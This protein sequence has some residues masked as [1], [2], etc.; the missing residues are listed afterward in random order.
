MSRV[1]VV[2]GGFAGMTAALRLRRAG[3]DVTLY[4]A[5]PAP[6]GLASPHRIGGFVWDRFY[7][8]ILLS[9]SRLLALLDDLGLSD[10]LRWGVTRTGFYTDGQLYSLSNSLEFLRF[11][12]LGLLDKLR[13]GLTIMRAARVKDWRALEAIP[14]SD[15]LRKWSGKRTFE[16]IWL[17][18]LKSKLGENYR[19]ASAS[20]IWATIAR[21]YAARRSGLKQEMFGY[22]AGGYARVLAK[23]EEHLR[24]EGVELRFGTRITAIRRVSDEVVVEDA[25]GE[26][27]SHDNVVLTIPTTRISGLVPQL[28]PD[29]KQRLD[30]VVYQ[31][32]VCVSLL[33]KQQLAGFYVTNIT[34]EWVPFTGVIEMTAL[35][36]PESFG[37]GHLVY[38][39]KYLTQQDPTWRRSD[40]DIIEECVTALEKM[41]PSFSRDLILESRIARAREVQAIATLRYSDTLLPPLETSIEGIFVVNSAQIAAGTLNLNET[42]GLTERQIEALLVK[43]GSERQVRREASNV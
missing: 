30:A 2:G 10:R 26:R 39:P 17:P 21:M 19:V 28:T 40:E 43:L 35:V 3:H 27:R 36:D 7:H 38:L 41:Y 16:R 25:A 29:E 5:A 11:P 37:G 31:G 34:E 18:L 8:V 14:V 20:F 6:G 1:G 23:F 33:L 12:P 42:I 15:W 32:V 13:L 4:E 22:V 9:D 24:D